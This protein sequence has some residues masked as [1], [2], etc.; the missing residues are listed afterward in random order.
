MMQIYLHS[1][2]IDFTKSPNHFT[3]SGLRVFGCCPECPTR[4]RFSLEPDRY[5]NQKSGIP[6]LLALAEGGFQVG[7]W[8]KLHFPRGRDC[9]T[10]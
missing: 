10:G 1:P 4:V 3:K 2:A 7:E 9:I 8:A 5:K 6:F